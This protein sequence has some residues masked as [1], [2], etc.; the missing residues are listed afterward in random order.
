MQKRNYRIL[1]VEDDA[2]DRYI[3]Q[4]AFNELSAADDV[5]MFCSGEELNTHL[6]ELPDAALPE[7]FVLDYNMPAINGAELALHLKGKERF[8]QIPVVLYSTGMSP[9]MQ[10]DL[11]QKGVLRCFEKGMEY[12]EVL[13]LARILL[14]LLP[15]GP[16]NAGARNGT[17][18]ELG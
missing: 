15:G 4:Q 9:K 7:L 1:L 3:M 18:F 6:Q 10:Q 11:L 13:D 17:L 2:D 12:A 14:Q 16:E 8:R 5:R